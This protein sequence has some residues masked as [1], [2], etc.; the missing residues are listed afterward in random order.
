MY[1]KLIKV[2]IVDIDKQDQF[3]ICLI[4]CK[5]NMKF[6]Y[7]SKFNAIFTHSMII[8]IAQNTNEIEIQQ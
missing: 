5:K 6:R 4:P 7:I 2:L 8:Q 1:Y 3:S